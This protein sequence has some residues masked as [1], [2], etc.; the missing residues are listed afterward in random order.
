ML[1]ISVAS[2]CLAS[3]IPAAS[4]ILS[5]VAISWS[6][7]E[8]HTLPA[9]TVWDKKSR[10]VGWKDKLLSPPSY[11][12]ICP[13]KKASRLKFS[14]SSTQVSLP[15]KFYPYR[16]GQFV[17]LSYVWLQDDMAGLGRDCPHKNFGQTSC[18]LEGRIDSSCCVDSL[19]GQACHYRPNITTGVL[20]CRYESKS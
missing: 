17:R 13:G 18:L 2:S 8:S 1:G 9:R 4:T 14:T 3:T 10:T 5:T 6:L 15:H 20:C 7:C 16:I 12:G 11:S 19:P